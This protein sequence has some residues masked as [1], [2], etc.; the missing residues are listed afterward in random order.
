VGPATPVVAIDPAAFGRI[1]RWG[2][3]RDTAPAATLAELDPSN[4]PAPIRLAGDRVQ[5]TADQVSVRSDDPGS[6]DRPQPVSLA[7]EVELPDGSSTNAIVPV[8]DTSRPST[9]T[10]RL[11]G[12]ARGCTLRRI[13]VI[14]AVGD[15]S[16]AEISLRL[17]RLAVGTGSRL[18]PV[19]LGQAGDGQNSDAAA[20]AAGTAASIRFSPAANG[21]LQLAVV[22]H[23]TGATLQHLDVPVNLPCLT[24]GSVTANSPSG[25]GDSVLAVHGV[26]GQ[27]AGCQPVGRLPF[28]P[29]FGPGTVLV[30]LDLSIASTQPVLTGTSPSV[31]LARDDPV[32]EAALVRGLAAAGVPVTGRSTIAQVQ[33]GYDRSPPAWAI[34]AALATAVLAALIAALMVVIAAYTSQASRS[35]DL[36]ALR[37]VGVSRRRIHRGVLAEQLLAVLFAA[38]LGSVVG[39]F[40]AR[41]ALP[42]VP[43]FID[44]PVV[45]AP[46]Y[47]TAWTPVLASIGVVAVV[48]VLAAFISAFVIEHR[49]GPD[50]LRG[51]A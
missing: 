49:V 15:F 30:D 25:A 13:E 37:L 39:L 23:G 21:A 48:L 12:C 17:L 32:R 44:R 4:A 41:L 34:R 27:S 45:P 11:G 2:S 6:S 9:S 14:R 1:A 20:A 16:A 31:W 28:A 3:A 35:Y 38:L 43:L 7:F 22:S 19:P 18:T 36:A 24:A 33:R 29:R 5:L 10:G 46:R 51:G 50:R 47:D 42:A 40:G 26:D 8:A